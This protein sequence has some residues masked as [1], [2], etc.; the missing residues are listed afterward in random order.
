MTDDLNAGAVRDYYKLGH[1]S[2]A[3]ATA[4]A[5]GA[6]AHLLL[7]GDSPVADILQ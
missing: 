3:A 5:L 2:F 7:F 6:R 4:G 1:S